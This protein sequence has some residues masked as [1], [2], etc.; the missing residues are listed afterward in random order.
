MLVANQGSNQLCVFARDPV[1]GK[2][3]D[4]GKSFAAAAPM[5][6]LFT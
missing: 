6:I 4:K 5:C 1:T 2:L 3:A